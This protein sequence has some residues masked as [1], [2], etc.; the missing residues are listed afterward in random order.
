[1]AKSLAHTQARAKATSTT[2]QAIG[3]NNSCA[4]LQSLYYTATMQYRTETDPTEE[5]NRLYHFVTLD[6]GKEVECDFSPY[7]TMTA[8]D[9]ETWVSLGC[10]ERVGVAPLNSAT[11]AKLAANR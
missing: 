7:A 4:S 10:P 1:M 9:V 6:N 2:S 11:L 8:Q 3:Q 5:G